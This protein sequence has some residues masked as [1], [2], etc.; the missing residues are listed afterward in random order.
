MVVALCIYSPANANGVDE[1]FCEQFKGQKKIWWDGIELK[2]GQIGRLTV[3][4]DTPLFKLEGNKRTY[5]RTL[6][7][8][9]FYRI[10]A[11]KPGLLSVGGGYFV[12]RDNTVSYQTP[13][14]NKLNAVKCIN[15][16]KDTAPEPGTLNPT[17]QPDSEGDKPKEEDYTWALSNK[18]S[19]LLEASEKNDWK[20]AAY[21]LENGADVNYEKRYIKPIYYAIKNKNYEVVDTFIKF[22]ANISDTVYFNAQP[23]NLAIKSN[24]AKLVKQLLDAGANVTKMN[25]DFEADTYLSL[26]IKGGNTEITKILI[27]YG[28]APFKTFYVGMDAYDYYNPYELA[29]SKGQTEVIQYMDSWEWSKKPNYPQITTIDKPLYSTTDI[30]KFLNE[31]FGILKTSVGSTTITFSVNPFGLEEDYWIQANYDSG[32]FLDIKNGT[33][34]NRYYDESTRRKVQDELRQY[35]ESIGLSIAKL[36]PNK[37]I[38]GGFYSSYYKYPN[39]KVGLV[40]SSYFSWKAQLG[41][42]QWD[43]TIDNAF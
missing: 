27:D 35:Q 16:I 9:E 2:T 3:I 13:S 25:S 6:K 17:P 19:N 31:N 38:R 32:F 4:K 37:H 33:F 22:G 14:K 29:M 10:Y 24:D 43:S 8:G 12:D 40:S 5:S 42:F 20:L 7:A 21:L 26:A 18:D 41:S 1:K 15:G 36:L 28:A 23:L 11:F 39:L 34:G 30:Q